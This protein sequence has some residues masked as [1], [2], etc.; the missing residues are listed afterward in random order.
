M[1][2]KNNLNR[3]RVTVY[4]NLIGW[5]PFDEKIEY[6]TF[7]TGINALLS[8]ELSFFIGN[9]SVVIVVIIEL[10]T[11][12]PLRLSYEELNTRERRQRRDRS[13]DRAATPQSYY[14]QKC[15]RLIYCA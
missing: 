13:L 6:I 7:H 9:I 12:I 8:F 4:P 2:V 3:L 11:L 1:L 15:T 10:V 14:Y 5:P